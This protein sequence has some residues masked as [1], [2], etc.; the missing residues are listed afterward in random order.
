MAIKTNYPP[1]SEITHSEAKISPYETFKAYITDFDR[2]INR[3]SQE[4]AYL[5]DI[6]RVIEDKRKHWPE[7]CINAYGRNFSE[8]EIKN[9]DSLIK[10]YYSFYNDEQEIRETTAQYTAMYK[11]LLKQVKKKPEQFLRVIELITAPDLDLKTAL[12]DKELM[13]LD[14]LIYCEE[15]DRLPFK[16]HNNTLRLLYNN[17][18]RRNEKSFYN[19]PNYEH[20]SMT[21]EYSPIKGA[22]LKRSDI[23]LEGKLNELDRF[24]LDAIAQLYNGGRR[25]FTDRYM[26]QL[27]TKKQSRDKI[28]E[29]IIN[30]VRASIEK[31]E[32]TQ[33]EPVYTSR[34]NELRLP[35]KLI[36]LHHA[37]LITAGENTK[38]YEI[39]G[40]PFYISY[41]RLSK[42]PQAIYSRDLL[43]IPISRPRPKGKPETVKANVNTQKLKHLIIRKLETLENAGDQ[44]TI[45]TDDIYRETGASDNSTKQRTR[46]NTE[47]ILDEYKKVYAISW[48][49]VTGGKKGTIQGYKLT[50][51]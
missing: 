9:G 27:Y 26:A 19:L 2:I 28:S 4:L 14:Y 35:N 13:F 46:R 17:T 25:T 18:L 38:G 48:E 50:K 36:N 29:D 5:N 3:I 12:N 51:I 37:E 39:L 8:D 45:K 21:L 16:V 23:D 43:Y 10:Q 6:D 20:L 15:V 33:I 30:E 1:K 11:S 44:V 31:L 22:D 49:A 40:E 24:I 32:N 7:F 47:L 34:L 42:S 41:L